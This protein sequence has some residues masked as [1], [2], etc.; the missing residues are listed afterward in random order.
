MPM[1][2]LSGYIDSYS[3][4]SESL[5]NLY[6]GEVNDDANENNDVESNRT[7]NSKVA[8]SKYFE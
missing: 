8:T 1:Y 6:A 4:T 2:N 3:M 7:N 5:W